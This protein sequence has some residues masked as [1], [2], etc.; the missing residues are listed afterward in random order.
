MSLS[1][2]LLK[3]T[4]NWPSLPVGSDAVASVAAIV[5]SATSSSVIVPAPVSSAS[6]TPVDGA[7]KTTV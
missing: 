7:L 3:L 2:A 5:T 4:V 1:D 6:V